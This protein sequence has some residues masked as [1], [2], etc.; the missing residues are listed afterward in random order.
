MQYIE[1][2]IALKNGKQALFRAPRKEDAGEM[3][4][5]L[6]KSASETPYLGRFEEEWNAVSVEQEGVF[7][8]NLISSENALMIVCTVDGEIA[9][10]CQIVFQT[11]VKMKHRATVMIALLEKFWNLGIG[12]AMLAELIAAA[13]ARGTEQLELQVVD[14]NER[15][16]ALYRKMGFAVVSTLPDAMRLPDG[17]SFGFLTMVKR[18]EK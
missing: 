7:L 5:Y 4:A 6:K 2:N 9:G 12:T 1:K 15:A 11:N 14:E 10:N 16:Q 17:R 3:I 8:Q 13:Q 18:L